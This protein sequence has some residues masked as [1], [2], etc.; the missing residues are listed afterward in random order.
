MAQ[1]DI[2]IKVWLLPDLAKG[3]I[4]LLIINTSYVK[5]LVLN[6]LTTDTTWCPVTF[7]FKLSYLQK[8]YIYFHNLKFPLDS[9]DLH[10]EI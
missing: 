9:N 3:T 1:R 4:Y 6:V 2:L 8:S 7:T 10:N 5:G